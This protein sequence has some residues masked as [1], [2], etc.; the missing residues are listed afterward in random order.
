MTRHNNAII[1]TNRRPDWNYWSGRW[2]FFQLRCLDG[3]KR[4]FEVLYGRRRL[5]AS[6]YLFANACDAKSAE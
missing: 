1:R 4:E 6:S 2:A 3:E 5:I